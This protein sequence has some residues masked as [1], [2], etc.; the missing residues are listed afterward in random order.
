MERATS[1]ATLVSR[2]DDEESKATGLVRESKDK[3]I[4]GYSGDQRK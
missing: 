4:T 1:T 3:I 2:A